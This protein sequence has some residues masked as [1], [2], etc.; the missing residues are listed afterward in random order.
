LYYVTVI[1]FEAPVTMCCYFPSKSCSAVI[2]PPRNCLYHSPMSTFQR[3]NW[4]G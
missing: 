1:T 4:L 2:L 3:R